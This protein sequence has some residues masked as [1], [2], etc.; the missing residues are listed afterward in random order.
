MRK[1]TW[2]WESRQGSEKETRR[3]LGDIVWSLSPSQRLFERK[4]YQRIVI[5]IQSWVYSNKQ[6]SKGFE[7]WCRIMERAVDWESSEGEGL[8][9]RP[10]AVKQ[11][12]KLQSKQQSEESEEL[13]PKERLGI[14]TRP[15]WSSQTYSNPIFKQA[16]PV[17]LQDPQERV[18]SA[19]RGWGWL[20]NRV[21]R[22]ERT[23]M[24]SSVF[25]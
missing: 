10:V 11:N 14:S 7:L 4:W 24:K 6:T 13:E 5:R 21:L 23:K 3:D 19:P 17:S 12:N 2:S 20:N 22:F 1:G 18:S 8:A 16:C 25:R 9:A 15:S